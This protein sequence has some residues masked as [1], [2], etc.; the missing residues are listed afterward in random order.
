V[1]GPQELRRFVGDGLLLTDDRPL[2]E[3]HRSLPADEPMAD[4]RSVKG[5]VAT[6]IRR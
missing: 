3:Y 5:D 4:L 2:V 6:L 1:A